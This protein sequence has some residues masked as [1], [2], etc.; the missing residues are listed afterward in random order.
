MSAT[1]ILNVSFGARRRSQR[2]RKYP[3]AELAL[4]AHEPPFASG[5]PHSRKQSLRCSRA[6]CTPQRGLPLGA[7]TWVP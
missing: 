6:P 5:V 7:V 2:G 1:V 4:P 3:F